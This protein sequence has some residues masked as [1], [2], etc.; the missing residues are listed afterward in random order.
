MHDIKP[1]RLPAAEEGTL[2]PGQEHGT[3]YRV[4]RECAAGLVTIEQMRHSKSAGWY[5]QRS[6]SVPVEVLPAILT[7]LRKADCYRVRRVGIV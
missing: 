1:L 3:A 4:R 2:I 6:F 5:V 7:E